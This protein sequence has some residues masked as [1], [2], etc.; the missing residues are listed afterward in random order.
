[1]LGKTV[2]IEIG[3]IGNVGIQ[4][5]AIAREYEHQ[6]PTDTHSNYIRQQ[7]A[8]NASVLGFII[9][10]ALIVLVILKALHQKT[11]IFLHNKSTT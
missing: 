7:C 1:L 4:D 5:E 6:T 8:L 2:N 10:L 9:S 3:T 11:S